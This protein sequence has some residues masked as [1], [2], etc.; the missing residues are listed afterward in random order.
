M[1]LIGDQD[2]LVEAVAAANPRTVVVLQ[3]GS[4]VRM[5][6][7]DKVAAVIQ[8]W[9]PGQEC[10]NAIADVLF[11]AV[12][13]SGRLPQ[14]FPM[15]LEDNPAYINY[16]G[17]NGKVRYGEGLFV[18]YRYYEKK[19]V[20]PLFPF[21][22]GL[23]YTT[24]EY[25]NLRLSNEVFDPEK[26]LK[27]MVDVT[28]TGARAGQEVVQL[29]VRDVVARLVR[30]EKELKAF[31]KLALQPGETQTAV[32]DFNLRSL[33]YYDDSRRA[34]VAEAG[35][36]EVLIGR[37]SADIRARARF[38]LSQTII[39]GGTSEP[40][41]RL[42]IQSTIR[43]LLEN[44]VSAAVLDKHL[45]GFRENTQL[46]MAMS[47]TLSQIANFVPDQFPAEKLDLIA[48]DLEAAFQAGGNDAG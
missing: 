29:Y 10:G 33:A 20:A 16:P 34:W 44:E 43:E 12:D 11:G 9:F 6:W 2:T 24:F 40:A 25:N 46:G 19:K 37:S 27:V 1:D 17:E 45:P 15:R 39:I 13:A 31:T 21:G 30:P 47:F 38:T 7:L 23:S 41:L 4:P 14:T 5:P 35:E 48:K 18:G 32:L 26:G 22:Y 3:T 8:A 42:S 36:F 28:N